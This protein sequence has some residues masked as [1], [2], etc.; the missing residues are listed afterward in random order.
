LSLGNRC[1]DK[2][3]PGAQKYQMLNRILGTSKKLTYLNLSYNWFDSSVI[4]QFL[5][6]LADNKCLRRLFIHNSIVMVEGVLRQSSATQLAIAIKNLKSKNGHIQ[7]HC[8]TDV[9]GRNIYL[10]EKLNRRNRDMYSSA[11]KTCC[12]FLLTQC[13][14]RGK[15]NARMKVTLVKDISKVIAQMVYSTRFEIQ[16]WHKKKNKAL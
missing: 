14:V 2:D 15:K 13:P 4:E 7:I 8:H 10:F 5:S 11:Q 1:F 9:K 3:V 12:A 16:T 6:L